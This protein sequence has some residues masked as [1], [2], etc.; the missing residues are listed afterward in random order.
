MLSCTLAL[1]IVAVKAAI[2]DVIYN[3]YVYARVRV[4]SVHLQP[5]LLSVTMA[6]RHHSCSPH[7]L[8]LVLH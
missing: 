7:A 4:S 8:L 6:Q 3:L 2:D 1:T 5:V